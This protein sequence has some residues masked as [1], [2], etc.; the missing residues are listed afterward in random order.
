MNNFPEIQRANIEELDVIEEALSKKLLKNPYILPAHLQ[1]KHNILIS[2]INKPKSTKRLSLQQQYELK[3]LN[4]QYALIL[5]DLNHCLSSEKDLFEKGLPDASLEKFDELINSIQESDEIVRDPRSLYASYSSL[6]KE[7][8]PHDSTIKMKNGKELEFVKRKHVLSYVA[9]HLKS[10]DISETLDLHRFHDVYNNNF[11]SMSYIEYLYKFMS[12]PYDK[13]NGS[14][15]TYLAELSKFLENRLAELYPLTDYEELLKS[16]KEEFKV[17]EGK[18]NEKGEVFCEPCNKLFA[19][20]T[21]YDAHL[22]G[23]KHK[24][25]E[26]N[27]QA[28]GS[29]I[30]WLE[31]LVQKL[32]E[33]LALDLE[34]TRS[35]VEKLANASER[36]LKLDTQLQ[37]DIENEFVSI[38]DDEGETE[39]E[40]SDDEGDDAFKNLPVGPDGAPIPYWLY[41]LQGLNKQYNCEVC[42]NITYKGKKVFV[43][44]FNEPKHQYG[45][46]CLG[47]DEDKMVLFKNIVKIDEV[48][49][50]WKLIKKD[51]KTQLN[52]VEIEDKEGNVMSEKD[53]LDLKKQGLL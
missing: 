43:K 40:L 30:P 49:Q 26:G 37:Y 4:D 12:F 33:E 46:K 36:E 7:K 29:L 32:C 27:T 21:V 45:L 9:S 16:W 44:H 47:I 42:G 11:G 31:H 48:V 14:Y 22:T 15:T 6:D 5:K 51:M 17:E 3:Y 20:Q 53:Y 34:F 25:N 8:Y 35:Q 10:L 24:K 13:T 18:P 39:E 19:K 2:K 23:K 28:Q 1:P 38:Q 50:L 41:K 52:E